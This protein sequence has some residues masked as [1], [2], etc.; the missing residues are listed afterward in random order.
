MVRL[1]NHSF[2][3][4]A[5]IQA[6]PEGRFRCSRCDTIYIK[7][8]AIENHVFR[9]NVVGD[10]PR[11]HRGGNKPPPP[12]APLKRTR[13]ER[14]IL[15]ESINRVKKKQAPRAKAL[16]HILTNISRAN[17]NGWLD[18]SFFEKVEE[19]KNNTVRQV[20]PDEIEIRAFQRRLDELGEE[21][22]I[23]EEIEV[24]E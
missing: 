17:A 16:A 14:D 21:D 9:S 12:P 6:L 2:I 23:E 8:P 4:T 1:Q 18:E 11:V 7:L 13:T 20:T 15:I 10:C 3:M 24:D 22:E 19:I 5:I